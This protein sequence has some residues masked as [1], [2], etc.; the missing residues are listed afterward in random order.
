MIEIS[1]SSVAFA[2]AVSV[3]AM[4]CMA[5]IQQSIST[6]RFAPIR[7]HPCL[8]I[9]LKDNMNQLYDEIKLWHKKGVEG[10]SGGAPE[11]LPKE[12]RAYIVLGGAQS[13]SLGENPARMY[14]TDGNRNR[15]LTSSLILQHGGRSIFN[16]RQHL[17]S[18]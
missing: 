16:Q 12:N 14:R 1:L 6:K 13:G 10:S 17:T 18:L 15:L 2:A 11:T 7:V 4:I 8:C 5:I 9:Y 3:A